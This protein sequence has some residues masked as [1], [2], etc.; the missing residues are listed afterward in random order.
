M[1]SFNMGPL[2]ALGLVF[3]LAAG[4][5]AGELKIKHKPVKKA[6]SNSRIEVVTSVIASEGEVGDV[7]AYFKADTEERFFYV[8]MNELEEKF[9]G[10]LPAPAVGVGGVEYMIYAVGPDKQFVKTQRFTIAIKD[11]EDALERMEQKEPTDIEI[12][13]DRIEQIRDLAR[14]GG[15]P[16]IS[17]RVDVRTELT[18]TTQPT[19]IPG[20]NDYIALGQGTPAAAGAGLA[21]ATTVS[22]SAGVGATTVIA[23]VA[24]AALTG[25][26]LA[27]SSETHS[28]FSGGT[29][30]TQSSLVGTWSDGGTTWNITQSSATSWR[31]TSTPGTCGGTITIVGSRSGS[32][33][34]ASFSNAEGGGTLNG[35]IG[36]GTTSIGYTFRYTSG[37]CDGINGSATLFR[38]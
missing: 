8:P 30:T 12:N 24:G 16:D 10:V 34:S 32:N 28:D 2:A 22:A 27:S 14:R 11:D 5:A 29:T 21:A 1:S 18:G 36:S 23:G 6:K 25:T 4:Q 26:A 3:V 20:F 17:H 7:R 15:Q 31:G 33:I 13:F 37:I 38:R 19:Q 9:I 35:V